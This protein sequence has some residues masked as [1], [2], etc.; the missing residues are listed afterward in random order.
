MPHI[1]IDQEKVFNRKVRED[2][3][4]NKEVSLYFGNYFFQI[5]FP[6]IIW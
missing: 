4:K 6:I 1:M 3:V 2:Y 5:R